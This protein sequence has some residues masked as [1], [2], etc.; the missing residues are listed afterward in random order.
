MDDV[1]HAT[2]GPA[3]ARAHAGVRRRRRRAP[4][5]LD[6]WRRRQRQVDIKTLKTTH[7]KSSFTFKIT[8]YDDVADA[9]FTTANPTPPPSATLGPRIL[10]G[11]TGNRVCVQLER[12]FSADIAPKQRLA[13]TGDVVGAKLTGKLYSLQLGIKGSPTTIAASRSGRTITLVVPKPKLPKAKTTRLLAHT[14]FLDAESC[15][16]GCWDLKATNRQQHSG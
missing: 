3:G 2:D 10:E 13:C 9:D 8:L 11:L 4:A 14:Q 7:T 6:G 16:T 12:R 15:A 5:D 1:R